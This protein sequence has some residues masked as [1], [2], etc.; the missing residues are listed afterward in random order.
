MCVENNRRG[1]LRLVMAA[2]QNGGGFFPLPFSATILIRPRALDLSGGGF[3]T[4]P[5]DRDAR[6][7]SRLSFSAAV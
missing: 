1:A 2:H 4:P 3:H 7:V 6:D 5:E